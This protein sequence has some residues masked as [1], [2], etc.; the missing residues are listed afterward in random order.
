MIANPKK[1]ALG[2]A[3]TQYLGFV[4]GQGQI[5][6]FA[7]KVQAIKNYMT[8]VS[9]RQLRPFE[10]WLATITDFSLVLQK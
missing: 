2:Q 10:A 5:R 9:K 6:P 8:P 1:Y 4:V 3:Q 7:D